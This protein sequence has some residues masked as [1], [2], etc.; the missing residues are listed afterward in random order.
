MLVLTVVSVAA[1]IVLAMV[2]WK[3]RHDDRLRRDARVAA[4]ASAID[5]PPTLRSAAGDAPLFETGRRSPMQGRPLLKVAIGF[6][7]A[8]AVI[9]LI[10]MTGDRG[11]RAEAV[12]AS[13]PQAQAASL[14]LVS[15]R[16]AR[17]GDQLTVTGLVRNAGQP[18]SER[19]IAVVLA[20]DRKGDFVASGRAPLEFPALSTGDESPFQ[21]TIPNV[22]DVGRYRVSFR[23]ETG[24]VRHVDRRTGRGSGAT[25]NRKPEARGSLDAEA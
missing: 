1:A 24:V 23:T 18:S 17:A 21:V 9:V 13:E 11:D 20:F 7:M 22:T 14:E 12:P 5:G 3:L 10:A 19:L 15:L 16:H 6:A 25:V 8:V 2:I 4:L